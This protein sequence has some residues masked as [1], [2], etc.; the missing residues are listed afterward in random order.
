MCIH[1]S[2]CQNDIR[3]PKEGNELRRKVVVKSNKSTLSWIQH[4]CF[5]C[6]RRRRLEVAVGASH[7]QPQG[8]GAA[9]LRQV[10]EAKVPYVS[11]W[12]SANHLSKNNERAALR[13]NLNLKYTW[14]SYLR[15]N[16]KG[17]E[18]SNSMD[19]RFYFVTKALPAHWTTAA[20]AVWE[21]IKRV[22]K[23]PY[24]FQCRN[25]YGGDQ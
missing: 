21:E 6:W 15:S 19:T 4:C 22:W 1:I 7:A 16:K 11:I 14:Q 3:M 5:Y 17:M 13:T 25:C 2:A 10:I 23:F 24:E 18:G 8:A 9:I 20:V 12:S